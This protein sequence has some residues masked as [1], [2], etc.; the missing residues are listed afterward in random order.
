MGPLSSELSSSLFSES[1]SAPSSE[2]TALIPVTVMDLTRLRIP[3]TVTR[4][5]ATPTTLSP[6]GLLRCSAP[7]LTPS[8]LT[9]R[10]TKK[11]LSQ[12]P[13]S[14]GQGHNQ[15]IQPDVEKSIN[16]QPTANHEH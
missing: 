10:N 15:Q 11:L 12:C 13:E 5:P 4:H 6:R 2:V 16:R 1:A 9:R 8:A 3:T 14:P 7:S